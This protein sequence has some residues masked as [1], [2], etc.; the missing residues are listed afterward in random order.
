MAFISSIATVEQRDVAAIFFS[1]FACDAFS[2]VPLLALVTVL[3]PLGG[4]IANALDARLGMGVGPAESPPSEDSG[5]IMWSFDTV[6]AAALGV[7]LDRSSM[8][9]E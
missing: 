3:R 6:A 7:E 1:S 8:A 4:Y 9:T 5:D 2:G